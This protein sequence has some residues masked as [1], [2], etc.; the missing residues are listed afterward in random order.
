MEQAVRKH[1]NQSSHY[2][3]NALKAVESGNAEKASEFLWGSMTQALKALAAARGK[4]IRSHGEIRKY[5][6]E[7][8][9]S[10]QD[11]SIWIAFE[12]ARALHSNFY[13]CGLLLEDVMMGAE[14][15]KKAI[16]KLFSLI[17]ETK[18]NHGE[19]LTYGQN[20]HFRHHTA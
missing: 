5:A 9:R 2:F 7:L 3:D 4:S 12:R 14:D 20:N 15:I 6:L 19:K 1:R 16:A 10:L 18:G 13:E 11:E 17:P 8:S